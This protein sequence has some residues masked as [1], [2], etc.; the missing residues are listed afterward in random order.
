[1]ALTATDESRAR[2]RGLFA[3]GT[4]SSTMSQLRTNGTLWSLAIAMGVSAVTIW[5][6][7][8]Q[9]WVPMDEG[10]IAGAAERVLHGALPHVDFA[11]PY[12]GGLPFF[13]AIAMHLFGVSL[14]AP[15]YALFAA[16]LFWLPAFWWLARRTS[17]NSWASLITIVAAWWSLPIYTA[18]MP[19]W[20]LLFLATWIV[21]ALERWQATG[22]DRW[23]AI[24]GAAVGAAIVIKQTGL[25]ILAGA[26]L[27]I[28][29]CEQERRFLRRRDAA[30]LSGYRTNPLIVSALVV[31]A[32]AIAVLLGTRLRRSGEWLELVIPAGTMLLLAAS[33]EVRLT[34]PGAGRLRELF[35]STAIL[36]VGAAVPVVLLVLPYIWIGAGH[37]L[38]VSVVREGATRISILQRGMPGAWTILAHVFPMYALLTL[39][40][41]AA[42]RWQAQVIGGFVALGLVALALLNRDAYSALWYFAMT[43]LPVAIVA[44]AYA[45]RRAW[46]GG[47]SLDPVILVVAAMTVWFSLHQ[48][49]YSAPNY[50]AYVAP[51]AILT[52]ALVSAHYRA[53]PRLVFGV[54][55]MA[56][57]AGIV[58]RLGSVHSVG[59]GTKWWDDNHRLA[60]PRGGLRVPAADSAL[61]T[62]LLRLVAEHRGAG[63][64]YAGPELP[65]VFFLSGAPSPLRQD[66]H[67]LPE[68]TTDSTQMSRRFDVN[69]ANMVL[70]NYDPLFL[71]PVSP[72]ILAWLAIRYPQ[73]ERIGKVEARWR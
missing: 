13:H 34:P 73:S 62:D 27:G 32:A 37:T 43:L 72:S 35:R 65:E 71:N 66:Y 52:A 64:V 56:A 54:I 50:F 11:Y 58:L 8:D 60:M 59:S 22:L 9:G 48:F 46:A 40:Y 16:Y 18:A 44:V 49:P 31:A 45:A 41:F 57:F 67:F 38:Y 14:M 15:R 70:I 29:L 53:L 17:G 51:L 63:T 20:F 69:G 10:T 25:Y 12:S 55:A 33:R 28:L 42:R 47:Q 61:Y 2:R 19:T 21:V 1:M 30:D 23:L 36:C 7:L 24:A 26:L 6:Q 68:G 3:G 5:S 39:G 4:G